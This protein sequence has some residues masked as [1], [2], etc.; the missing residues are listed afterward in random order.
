[1]NPSVSAVLGSQPPG[2]GTNRYAGLLDDVRIFNRALTAEQV[3]ALAN[4]LGAISNNGQVVSRVTDGL[5]ALYEFGEGAGASVADISNVGEP[6]DLTIE[7]PA[8]VAWV[9]NRLSV[10]E[11]T[12]LSSGGKSVSTTSVVGNQSGER[13]RW[14]MTS[15][16]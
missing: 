7:D 6:L 9:P 3:N 2:A 12:L 16:A 11:P 5:V 8:A 10:R 4:T 1:M 14:G 15:S 13:L